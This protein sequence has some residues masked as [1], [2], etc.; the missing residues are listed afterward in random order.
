[1]SA[2]D[3]FKEHDKTCTSYGALTFTK[4]EAQFVFKCLCLACG[5]SWFWDLRTEAELDRL[6][7]S[8]GVG[9]APAHIVLE[10]E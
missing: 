10:S 5:K 7:L 9:E 4:T 1:M 2:T 3:K 8:A 6:D